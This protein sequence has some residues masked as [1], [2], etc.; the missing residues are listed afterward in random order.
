MIQPCKSV[1]DYQT[2]N[3]MFKKKKKVSG[4][5]FKFYENI[6]TGKTADSTATT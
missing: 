3:K 1:L 5:L 2:D 6:S 4:F